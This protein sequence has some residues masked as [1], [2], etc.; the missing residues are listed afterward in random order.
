MFIS[1]IARYARNV[2]FSAAAFW[3]RLSKSCQKAMLVAPALMAW[4][5]AVAAPDVGELDAAREEVRELLAEDFRALNS[6]RLTLLEVADRVSG[7]ASTSNSAARLRV[8][9]EGAFNLYREAGALNRAAERRVPFWINLGTDAEFELAACPAGSFTMG[10]DG[11]RA[12]PEFRHKV[13]LPRPFWIAKFQTT[14]RLYSTFRRVHSMTKEEVLYGGMDVPQG[15][16]P[17]KD[18][19]EFCEF[20]TRRE[21]GRIPKGYVFRLPTDAEWEYALNANCSD[22]GDPYVK[23]RNGDA[24]AAKEIAVS[25]NSVNKLRVEHGLGPIDRIKAGQGTVF[26]VGT[27]RPNAWGI[28]DMLGNGQEYVLD[29]IPRDSVKRP[30]GEGVINGAYDMGYADEETEPLRQAGGSNGLV[31]TRGGM[32]YRRFGASW[33][34]RTAVASGA[35]SNGHFVFRIALAPDIIGEREGECAR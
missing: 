31:V 6:G 20:L 16:L 3:T 7:L 28:Y 10:C 24:S 1:G 25:W 17:R 29:T 33:Y 26:A 9:Q 23:F 30:W 32:R 11:D 19:V 34:S 8:L 14:K 4:L 22:P 15:G 13:N 18:I 35:H 27:R 2:L 5:G 21:E 12:S